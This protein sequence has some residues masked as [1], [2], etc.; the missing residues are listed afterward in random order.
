MRHRARAGRP[1]TAARCA[2]AAV[3]VAAA[4][5]TS[6]A[7]TSTPPPTPVGPEGSPSP[8]PT[9]LQTPRPAP[10]PPAIRARLA[11]L[12]DMSTG[13]VL[14]GRCAADSKPI[15]SLP[16][17]MTAVLVLWRTNHRVGLQVGREA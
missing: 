11:V 3:L 2:A 4:L 12:E 14:Y 5:A 7:A 13:Q 8:F 6:A 1:K 15:A 16:K 9:V 17:I 10:R